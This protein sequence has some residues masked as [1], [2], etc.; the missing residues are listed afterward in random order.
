MEVESFSLNPCNHVKVRILQSFVI[1]N[2][3]IRILLKQ[4]R[5]FV[6]IWHSCTLVAHNNS[7]DLY[8]KDSACKGS[9]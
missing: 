4:D 2:A 8:L 5:Y 9:C 3:S 6:K 1:L 7:N